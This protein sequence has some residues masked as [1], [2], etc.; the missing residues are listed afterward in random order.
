MHIFPMIASLKSERAQFDE[1][2]IF[3]I[4][5]SK[6][7]KWNGRKLQRHYCST[8][9]ILDCQCFWQNRDQYFIEKQVHQWIQDK[10]WFS[11]FRLWMWR[12]FRNNQ[13]I[14]PIYFHTYTKQYRVYGKNLY[15]NK[16][17][18]ILC[19]SIKWKILIKKALYHN[20]IT[21]MFLVLMAHK[22]VL[23]DH[24]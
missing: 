11:R 5:T 14:L 13:F 21:R 23:S 22:S 18:R 24:V 2:A 10:K 9:E 1:I 20:L 7:T 3:C 19:I 4:S 12:N 6:L 15:L 17:K 8:Q 16:S